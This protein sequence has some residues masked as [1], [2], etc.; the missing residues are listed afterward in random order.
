MQTLSCG[1]VFGASDNMPL[2][3]LGYVL[4]ANFFRDEYLPQ[5]QLQI[6]H[7]LAVSKAVNARLNHE[8]TT[9]YVETLSLL[10]HDGLH[11]GQPRQHNAHS[12]E[13]VAIPDDS[14]TN[15]VRKVIET[16]TVLANKFKAKAN[17]RNADYAPYVAA[18]LLV[19]DS[20]Q[21]GLV[22]LNYEGYDY[23]GHPVATPDRI[24]SVG[25]QSERLFYTARMLCREAGVLPDNAVETTGQVFTKHV[26]PPY[27]TARAG[28]PSLF[29]IEILQ[30][31]PIE[32]ENASVQRDLRYLQEHTITH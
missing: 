23:S 18:H 19:H 30:G 5:A 6:V 3:A 2:R 26:L 22:P 21:A 8:A 13:A 1:Y 24:I 14:F 31:P 16:N 11:N 10:V 28:E 20:H 7:P 12:L 29:D 25:A 4:S 27:L 15:A 17:A 9:T 32:N